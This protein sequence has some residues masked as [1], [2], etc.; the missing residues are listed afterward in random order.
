MATRNTLAIV[1]LVV[2][3]AIGAG[4]G[5]FMAPSGGG[6]GPTPP[7]VEKA[8]LQG[9]TVQIGLFFFLF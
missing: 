7:P 3:L 8:P 9:K 6:N 5:Y 1:L 2:G 4:A